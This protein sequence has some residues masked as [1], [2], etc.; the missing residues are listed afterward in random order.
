ML[1]KATYIDAVALPQEIRNNQYSYLAFKERFLAE[2]FLGDC[3]A[4]DA[5]RR[6]VSRAGAD[7]KG[8]PEYELKW[9]LPGYV[10]YAKGGFLQECR[11]NHAS[12]K[13]ETELGHGIRWAIDAKTTIELVFPIFHYPTWQVSIDGKPIQHQLDADTGLI[14]ARVPAGFSRVLIQWSPS[15]VEGR[16]HLLSIFPLLTLFILMIFHRKKTAALI[17]P[18]ICTEN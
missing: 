7:Y 5:G 14:R 8:V 1:F 10:D 18:E 4:A 11:T 12:C 15:V 13:I 2:G 6:Q 17:Q 16:R 3:D 9:N